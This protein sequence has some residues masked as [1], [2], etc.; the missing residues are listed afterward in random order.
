MI[1][2]KGRNWELDPRLKENQKGEFNVQPEH[3]GN[4]AAYFYENGKI[5]FNIEYKVDNDMFVVTQTHI[6][7][8]IVKI[9]SA[10]LSI[11]LKELADATF[12]QPPY[13]KERKAGHDR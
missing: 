8:G 10:P 6:P 9:L 2:G 5:A 12:A 4:R 1:L 11:N 7:T 13:A 3:I